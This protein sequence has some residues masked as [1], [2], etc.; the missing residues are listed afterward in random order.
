MKP[1]LLIMAAGMGSRYGGLKQIDPVGPGGETILDYSVYDAIK[2]GFGKIVFIIRRDIEQAFIETYVHKLQKFIEVEWV[3]QETDALPQGYVAPDGRTKPWGTGHAVLMARD[4][5][6]QPFAVINADDFYGREAFATLSKYFDQSKEENEYAM[7]AYR[8][9]NT[10]SDFG[11][12]SRGVCVSNERNELKD[13]TERTGIESTNGNISYSGP[14]EE[15]VNLPDDTLVS[16]N[17]WGFKPGFFNY[18][19]RH[20]K[21]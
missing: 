9:K 15:R 12:V 17:F 5:I 1:T 4:N 21:L 11:T 2:A 3:F 14:D 7:V 10:L 18:L 6:T 16:M 13:V 19:E 8:L 20:F